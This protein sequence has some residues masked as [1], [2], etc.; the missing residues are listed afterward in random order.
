MKTALILLIGNRDVQIPKE[1]AEEL[2][3]KI[4]KHLVANNEGAKEY[5]IINKA[6][7]AELTFLEASKLFFDELEYVYPYLDYPM[8]NATMKI[9]DEKK[10]PIDKVF[11]TTSKQEKIHFQD[12]FYFAEIILHHLKKNGYDSE[13]RLCSYNPNDFPK[14][15]AY[16]T[17]LFDEVKDNKFEQVVV[18]NSG[19]TPNMR[20]AS[21]FAGIFRGFEYITINSS[22]EAN[23][24]TFKR[25]EQLVLKSIVTSMLDVF[26]YEGITKLPVNQPEIVSLAKYALARIALNFKIAQKELENIKDNSPFTIDLYSQLD[27]EFDTKSLIKEMYFSAKV[28]F[29]QK[30]YADYLWRLFTIHDNILLPIVEEKLGGEVIHDKKTNFQE[31]LN[32]IGSDAGLISYLKGKEIDGKPLIWEIPGK[33]VYKS[34]VDYYF[35]KGTSFRPPFID[36]IDKCLSQLSDLRNVI[37]HQFGFNKQKGFNGIGIEEMESALP[38]K[39]TID[40]FNELLS[41]HVGVKWDDAGVYHQIN[42]KINSLIN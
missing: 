2:K 22:D 1:K 23:L 34:I 9:L 4:A 3:N 38:K 15:V 13:L 16:Y 12:S 8:L 32:L 24:E 7:D 26:D 28:R 11:L 19:G 35:P 29:Y 27:K 10:I 25:Q 17:A 21:H 37:A 31:W 14:M 39:F 41:E 33:F 30:S 5:L 20:S 40:S 36:D 6:K 18:S 42:N